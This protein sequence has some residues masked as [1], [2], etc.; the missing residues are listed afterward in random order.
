MSW[1]LA[2]I[3]E[4]FVG[5]DGHVREERVKI[6]SGKFKQTIHKLLPSPVK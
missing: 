2:V 6:I 4:I 1:R 5:S 3:S